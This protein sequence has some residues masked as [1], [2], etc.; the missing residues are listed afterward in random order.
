MPTTAPQATPDFLPT[1]AELR[2]WVMDAGLPATA[3]PRELIV[4]T[5]LPLKGIGKIDRRALQG[6]LPETAPPA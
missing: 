5:S 4:R 2:T 6:S 3:A 1:L